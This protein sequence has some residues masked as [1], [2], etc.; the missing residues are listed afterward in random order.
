MDKLINEK[1]FIKGKTLKNLLSKNN[2]TQ[3]DLA[4]TLGIDRSTIS[5]IITNK[6]PATRDFVEKISQLLEVDE[7]EFININKP[8]DNNFRKTAL[9]SKAKW[10]NEKFK[11]LLEQKNYMLIEFCKKI[12]TDRS[13]FSSYSR[14]K[15]LPSVEN[16]VKMCDVLGCSSMDL[17][18]VSEEEINDYLGYEVFEVIE[19]D[20]SVTEDIKEEKYNYAHF[21]NE[22]VINNLN[23]INENIILL[24]KD[25]SESIMILTNTVNTLVEKNNSLEDEIKSLETIITKT[26]VNSIN[27][28]DNTVIKNIE[29]NNKEKTVKNTISHNN[30]YGVVC[31]DKEMQ[32]IINGDCK[33]DNYETYKGK[34]YKL[35]AYMSRKKNLIF[36]QIM[37]DNYEKFK[38][39]YGINLNELKKD[40]KTS[41]SLEAIYTN[42]LTRELFFNMV[43]DKAS[44]EC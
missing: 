19:N 42:E 10:N 33:E 9:M 5:R 2:L 6:K 26:N 39:V 28:E 27:K 43:C 13:N 44:S 14:G 31:S 25:F 4:D 24:V 30:R 8:V 22:N 37:H 38:V 20:K 34:I 12:K 3:N 23:I 29:T 41:S 15:S 7:K 16:L 36:N 1:V 32:T 40:T 11:E 17:V 35:A 21:T 18:G